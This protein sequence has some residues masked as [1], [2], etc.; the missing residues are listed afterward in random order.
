MLAQQPESAQP[1]DWSAVFLWGFARALV[2]PSDDEGALNF[3]ELLNQRWRDEPALRVELPCMTYLQSVDGRSFQA[4]QQNMLAAYDI[5]QTPD[6]GAVFKPR[7]AGV[8][9]R[10]VTMEAEAPSE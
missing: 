4:C 3:V 7:V 9:E 8:T 5:Q 1:L 10:T 2:S 6:G